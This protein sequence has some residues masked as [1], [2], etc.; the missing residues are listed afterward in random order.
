[1][2]CKSIEG[3]VG[4]IKIY[5]WG[6]FKGV[7][8]FDLGWVKKVLNLFRIVQMIRGWIRPGLGLD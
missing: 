3:F 6:Y 7:E 8:I 4:F 2:L 1:M 5:G